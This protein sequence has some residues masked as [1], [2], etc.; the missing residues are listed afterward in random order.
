MD[1]LLPLHRY[2][3]AGE[4]AEVRTNHLAFTVTEAAQLLAQH[5]V[6]LTGGDLERLTRHTEGWAAGI[7]LAALSLDG[8]PDPGQFIKE[9]DSEDS[10]ITGYLV[11]EVLSAQ[12]PA[13]RKLLL[14]TS[15][16]DRV[17]ADLA[18]ELTADD[19]AR[20]LLSGLAQTNAFVQPVGHGWY[21][22][23]ALFGTAL[24]LKLRRES[25]GRVADLHRRAAQWFR[26]NGWLGEAVRHAGDSGDWPLAA[27]IVLDELA[28]G[29]LLEPRPASRSSRR[30]SACRPGRR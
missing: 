20:S 19:Q 21:R 14:R 29:R 25:P 12:P 18:D 23:H 22:Y 13:T 17:S 1:P 6:T 10:T 16:L 27:R 8:H 28:V 15:I 4:L 7:R 2:R 11:D 9:L 24:R 26:R 5:G 30:S 3:L